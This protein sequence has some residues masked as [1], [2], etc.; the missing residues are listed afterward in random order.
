MIVLFYVGI[1]EPGGR[2]RAERA[3]PARLKVQDQAGSRHALSQAAKRIPPAWQWMAGLGALA[4]GP[5]P[6]NT[7]STKVPGPRI[8]LDLGEHRLLAWNSIE[9]DSV[10]VGLFV[11]I[12]SYDEELTFGLTLDPS[13]VPD[14]WDAIADLQASC[15]GLHEAAGRV[16]PASEIGSFLP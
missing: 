8:P 11:T 10:S 7:G 13:V 6:L 9:I 1:E 16:N 14:V 2:R 5:T 4:P 15:A 12:L 3:A